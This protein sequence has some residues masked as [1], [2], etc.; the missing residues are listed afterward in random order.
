MA[1]RRFNPL[2]GNAILVSPNRMARP[3][4]GAVSPITE[5]ERAAY[6]PH[7]P[8]CPGNTRISGEKNP[9]YQGGYIFTNDTP[10]L[11]LPQTKADTPIPVAHPLLCETEASGACE[12]LCYHPAHNRPLTRMTAKEVGSVI[13]MW[14]TRTIVHAKNED[15]R[16][17]AIFETQGAALGNSIPHPHGQLWAS[18]HIPS[19]P[20][21]MLGNQ[22]AY[23]HAY[24]RR[25]LDDYLVEELK[26]DK[27]IVLQNEHFVALVPFWAEWP[28]E[29]MIMPR[30]H[31]TRIDDLDGTQ[32]DALAQM[33]LRALAIYARIFSRPTYGSAYFLALY[34]APVR[35]DRY[36]ESQLFLMLAPPY[37][38]ANRLKY[39]AGYERYFSTQR[40]LTPEEAVIRLKQTLKETLHEG[41]STCETLDHCIPGTQ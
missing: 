10:A 37:L 22:R 20:L 2:T 12:V 40:D 30:A 13:H 27:R 8:L 21:T 36:P 15:I 11:L 6:D 4:Q 23:H 29:M 35:G 17:V 25:L 34:Q 33:L 31:L 39:P 28:Y 32:V 7:C 5:E 9:C 1:S 26:Q 14:Q 19:L 3:W 41:N 18:S 24:R 38:T 16:Y